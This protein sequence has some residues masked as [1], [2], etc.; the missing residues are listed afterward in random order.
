MRVKEGRKVSP[1]IAI[2]GLS[3]AKVPP[4]KNLVRLC[5]VNKDCLFVTIG[6]DDICV[7]PIH[8]SRTS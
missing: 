5:P 3:G 4:G 1:A 6:E 2:E 8:F 7:N